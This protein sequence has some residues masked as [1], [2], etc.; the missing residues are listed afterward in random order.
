MEF[1]NFREVDLEKPVH[2][3]GQYLLIDPCYV[4]PDEMWDS[5]CS[6]ISDLGDNPM[7]FDLNGE[8]AIVFGTAY[9]DGCYPVDDS[10]NCEI[11]GECGVDAELLSFL[12]AD[13]EVLK[14]K[15]GNHSLGVLVDLDAEFEHEGGDARVG[16]ISVLTGGHFTKDDEYENYY[17]EDTEEEEYEDAYEDEDE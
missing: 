3:V 7:A 9:G 1:T 16:N 4:I 14:G 17:D 15:Y 11:V 5:F 6:E 8:T 10:H 12:P 13:E 2:L